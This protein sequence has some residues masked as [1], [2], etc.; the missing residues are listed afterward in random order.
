MGSEC[1]LVGE[2]VGGGLRLDF[3]LS[4]AIEFRNHNSMVTSCIN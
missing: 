2:G 4:C 1:V 3:N